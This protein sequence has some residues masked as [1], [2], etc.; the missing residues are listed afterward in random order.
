VWSDPPP[1]LI[2]QYPLIFPL[3]LSSQV[4]RLGRHSRFDWNGFDHMLTSLGSIQ[5]FPCSFVCSVL[6]SVRILR[7]N[8][9]SLRL[10]ETNSTSLRISSPSITRFCQQILSSVSRQFTV[11]SPSLLPPLLSSPHLELQRNQS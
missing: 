3:I 9:T 11:S 1:A 6:T 5:V 8:I 10:V 4:T 2:P 7:S